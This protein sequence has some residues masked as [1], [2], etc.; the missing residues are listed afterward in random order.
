MTQVHAES[1]CAFMTV[2]VLYQTLLLF[3]GDH[4]SIPVVLYFAG[5]T[6]FFLCKFDCYRFLP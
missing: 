6:F 3:L 4:S 1:A 2:A 5:T